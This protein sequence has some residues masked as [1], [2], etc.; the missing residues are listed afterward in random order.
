MAKKFS[1][2]KAKMPPAD[3]AEAEA[4]T[5][6]MMAEM[7]LSE[8]RKHIGLTQQDLAE[9]VGIKQPALSQLESQSD[10]Q[11]STLRR[12]IE[13]LGGHLELVAHLPN[14]AVRIGQFKAEAG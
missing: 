6:N 4:M 1:D 3:L 9:A 7:L 8:I 14:G 13:G 2:L 11:I 10:M 5:K 12:L